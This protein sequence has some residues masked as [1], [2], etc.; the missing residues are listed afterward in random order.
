M[1]KLLKRS[2]KKL[3]KLITYYLMK[4][5]KLTTINLVTQLLRVVAVKERPYFN[6]A[7]DALNSAAALACFL[8]PLLVLL[9]YH[10]ALN[11]LSQEAGTALLL[12]VNFG[13]P[14]VFLTFGCV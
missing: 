12:F 2:S 4:R 8:N 13:L 5:E 9:T 11:T 1:T 14:L 3:V 7:G 6:A 10:G